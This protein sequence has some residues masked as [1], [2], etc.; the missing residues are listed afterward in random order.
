MKHPLKYKVLAVALANIFAVGAAQA[1]NGYFSEGTGAKNRGLG[2]AGTALAQETG[3]IVMNPAAAVNMDPRIDIGV[4]L[5]NPSPRSVTIAGNNCTSLPQPCGANLDA[6]I[7]STMD[8]FLIPFYGQNFAIDN[9][10]SWAVTVSALGGMNTDYETHPFQA[11][12]PVSL[13]SLGIDLKQVTI[14]GTYARK[15]SNGF[16]VGVTLALVAQQFQAKGIGIFGNFDLSTNPSKMSNNGKSRST[17]IGLNLGATYDM[18]NGVTV[19][20]AYAPKV[21]MSE[22][23]E[24]AGLFAEGG[25]FDIPSNYALG[26]AW[27]VNKDVLVSFDYRRIN[28]TDVAAVSNDAQR[29]TTTCLGAAVTSGTIANNLP[30][31]NTDPTCLGGAQGAGFGWDDMDIFKL[32]V[33]WS[34]D[35]DTTYRAGWNH[36]S[37]PIGSE[38]TTLNILAPAVVED[39]L[40]LGMTTKLDATSELTFDYI[41]TLGNSVT[42]DLPAAFGGG[43]A[44]IEMSQNFLEVQYGKRF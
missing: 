32:G 37:S 18:G 21:D 7:E 27:E 28:Y 33:A 1:T 38:D 19:A 13:G 41:R 36:G 29:L 39:H 35:A 5:F 24:Y 22:F 14:G 2:G 16:S 42:G 11:F 40:S 25:D 12:S 15:V 30:D 17:G 10:S 9:K 6:N 26:V 23:D 31:A 44:T 43:Q 20:F 4:G 8:Y 34:Q 3:S